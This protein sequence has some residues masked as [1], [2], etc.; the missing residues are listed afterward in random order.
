VN[1]RFRDYTGLRP[2]ELYG[3]GWKSA[4]H[5][6]DIQ[7]LESWSQE[8]R[9]S[10]EA[11]TTEV[12]LRRFDGSYRWFLVFANPLRDESGSIVAWYGANI[13][14]E[15]RKKAEAD[16][17]ASELSWRQIVDN[18]PGFVNTAG[19]T[20]E[21]KFFNRQELEYF[22]KTNEEMKDW[23][24]NGVVHPEDLPN[25]IETWATSIETG[26]ALDIE[27][28]LRRADGVYRWFQIRALQREMRKAR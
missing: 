1:Q 26:Q 20:G 21:S 11:G 27:T 10:Q 17:R 24:R 6:D 16:L 3:S 9:H 7:V 19:A 5:R 13:D 23:S 14:I 25:V 8:T 18:I 28:R 12:R 4:V 22:G 15:D 2:E